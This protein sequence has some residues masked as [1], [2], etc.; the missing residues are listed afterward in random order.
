MSQLAQVG[1]VIDEETVAKYLRIVP[2]RF[3]QIALSIETMLDMSTLSIED[4]TGRLKAVE[5]CVEVPARTTAGGQL[6]LIEEQWAARVREKKQGESSSAPRGGGR[7]GAC[8]RRRGK[9]RRKA[10]GADK[11]GGDHVADKDRA[12]GRDCK[13]PRRQ[14]RAHLAQDDEEEPALLMA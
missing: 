7:S 4:I 9:P 3:A 5:D 8:G 13:E 6:L 10:E 12:L 2:P 1:V 11:D 14:E